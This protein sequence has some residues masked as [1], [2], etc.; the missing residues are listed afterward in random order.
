MDK[1]G[2]EA[3]MLAM[4]K[5]KSGAESL[6]RT[7]PSPASRE[8]LQQTLA[9]LRRLWLRGVSKDQDQGEKLRQLVEDGPWTSQV[10]KQKGLI[11]DVG[12]EDEAL[13][14]LKKKTG[15]KEATE[16]FGP[17]AEDSSESGVA[18]IVR[19]LAGARERTGGKKRIALVPAVGA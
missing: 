1:V 10:A 6:T 11:S 4:G 14:E 3:D 19:L 18:E 16:F 13:T 2:V 7:E 15:T 17:Q 5:Y 12:F 9:H 8:N